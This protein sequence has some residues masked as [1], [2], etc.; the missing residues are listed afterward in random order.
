MTMEQNLNPEILKILA[1]I[2]GFLGG[3]G[4]IHFVLLKYIEVLLYFLYFNFASS[5][6]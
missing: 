5:N 4:S 3:I 1:I 6:F 2:P